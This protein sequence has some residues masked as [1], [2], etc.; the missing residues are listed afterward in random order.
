[1][2]YIIAIDPSYNKNIGISWM[3]DKKL[4]FDSIKIAKE[5]KDPDTRDLGRIA[6]TVFEYI[7]KFDLDGSDIVGIEGQFFGVNKGM[8]INLITVRALIQGMILVKYPG[9]KVL[10]I[11]PR[12]W[13]AEILHAGRCKSVEIKEKSIKY[14][15]DLTRKK[16]SEDEADAICIL[17]Y[18]EKHVGDL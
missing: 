10:T 17:K 18:I 8:T 3:K 14:A 9:I 5:D 15:S 16:V 6:L 2:K 4:Y 1:M 11:D 7:S 13:Q 12:T